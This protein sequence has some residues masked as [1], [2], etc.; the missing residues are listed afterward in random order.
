M[1]AQTYEKLGDKEKAAEYYRKALAATSH[2][3][4]AAYERYDATPHQ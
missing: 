4:Q 3:P 1:I 2:T